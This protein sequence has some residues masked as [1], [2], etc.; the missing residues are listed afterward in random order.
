VAVVVF[1][2]PARLGERL[3]HRRVVELD[4]GEVEVSLSSLASR[5]SEAPSSCTTNVS[6]AH[7]SASSSVQ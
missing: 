3:S 5:S 6:A 4:E 1:V 7:T 2:V